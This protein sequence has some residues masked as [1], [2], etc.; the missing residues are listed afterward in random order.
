VLLKRMIGEQNTLAVEHG[1]NPVWP[2]RA[3]VVQLEQ[4][5]INL[6]VNARDAMSNG[7]A[8]THPHLAMSSAPRPRP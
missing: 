5:I 1:R 2:V 3:D 4:V 7:G 6:V 8:I